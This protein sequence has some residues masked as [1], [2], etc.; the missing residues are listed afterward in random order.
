MS[1]GPPDAVSDQAKSREVE[2]LHADDPDA[3]V[4]KNNVI[5]A[6][7]DENILKD[8]KEE[9]EEEPTGTAPKTPPPITTPLSMPNLADLSLHSPSSMIVGTPFSDI[10]STRFEYPFPDKTST[11][12]S[13]ELAG[14]SSSPPQHSPTF[15][16]L[17]SSPSPSALVSASQPQLV[18]NAPP[19]LQHFPASFPPPSDI[20]NSYSPTHPKM[21]A[22][23]PPPVPPALVKRRQRW[24]L[25]LGSL[26][27]KIS[28]RTGSAPTPGPAPAPPSPAA[29]ESDAGSSSHHRRA[30][31]D[32]Q[33]SGSG[34]VAFSPTRM[35]GKEDDTGQYT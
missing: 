15:S 18:L 4:A 21:R 13:P 28:L 22:V 6:D 17:S 19:A 23:N 1:L 26:T 16:S 24:T 33:A 32:N 34:E 35:E 3:N 8:K 14:P 20:P 12:G 30:L 9:E 10:N 25:G 2:P 31:S 27:R 11:F 5:G 29:A 7:E